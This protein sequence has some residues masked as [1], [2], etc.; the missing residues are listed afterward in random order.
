MEHFLLKVFFQI[1]I[2]KRIKTNIVFFL[3]II[4]TCVFLLPSC[5][6]EE[7]IF[8]AEDDKQDIYEYP[9][10]PVAILP[11]GYFE[12]R[13]ATG[14]KN[15]TKSAISGLDG[16]V[17][18][19][20][21]VIYKSTGEYVKEKVVWLPSQGTANWPMPYIKDT[22]PNGSYNA[23][24]LGN[25]EK[26]LFPYSSY[27]SNNDV[28]LNYQT[29]YNDARIVLPNAEFLD[30]TEYYW[31]KTSFSDQSPTTTVLLQRIIGA[32]YLHRNFVDAQQAL[33]TLLYNIATVKG[34]HNF[35]QNSV[36]TQLNSLLG[37]GLLSITLN[38]LLN[39]TG[40]TLNQVIR[41]LVVPVTTALYDLLLENITNQL[42]QALT[43][44]ANQNGALAGLGALLNPWNDDQAV[45]AVVT[46]GNFPKSVDFDL[47][48]KELYPDGTRLKYNFTNNNIYAEKD[49]PIKGFGNQWN[50]QKINIVKSG[51]ISGVVVDGVIDSWLLYGTFVDINDPLSINI[52]TNRRYKDNY[53]FLD[54][55]ASST[56]TDRTVSVSL[57]LNQV[58]NLDDALSQL[59]LVGSVVSSL[60]NAILAAV[61]TTN[62]T[63][64][65]LQVP[66]LNNTNLVLTGSWDT[67]TAY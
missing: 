35:I 31:A 39:L 32:S 42:G 59:G 6:K 25:V 30:N 40:I 48:V 36:Q 43:G 67:P 27:N 21:Y 53:S 37:T 18:H 4:S 28:L 14:G 38:G 54:L 2:M 33:D 41:A 64:S 46:V 10:E 22:L 57:R 24:F 19:V 20:R 23:V 5:E 61:G 51:L 44:N 55:K 12:V 8:K 52:P 65:G 50:I 17:Q 45:A 62:I 60:L 63:I 66:I 34:Y 9:Y 11:E 47:G 7:S 3:L 49:I 16:R 56:A 1:K 58:A 26:T 13:F 15:V 29:I